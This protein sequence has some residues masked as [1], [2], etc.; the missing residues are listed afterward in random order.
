MAIAS[1]WSEKVFLCLLWEEIC[2]EHLPRSILSML[3]DRDDRKDKLVS[4]QLNT[5]F[6][7]N[8]R[9]SWK[10]KMMRIDPPASSCFDDQLHGMLASNLERDLKRSGTAH[11]P[12]YMLHYSCDW[13]LKFVWGAL[14][15]K[16]AGQQRWMCD[17]C[18]EAFWL[19]ELLCV[20]QDS[21]QPDYLIKH[22]R[23]STIAPTQRQIPASS[24]VEQQGQNDLNDDS[25]FETSGACCARSEDDRRYDAAVRT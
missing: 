23:M 16:G 4:S 3:A 10:R 19:L 21:Q 6:G 7:V 22:A 24:N 11:S 5:K 13:L 8:M 2:S 20:S 17:D 25:L 15:K 1:N 14:Q 18:Q 12:L 9:S